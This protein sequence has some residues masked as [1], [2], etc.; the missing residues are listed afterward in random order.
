MAAATRFYREVFAHA[1]IED[2][3]DPAA[4]TWF[5]SVDDGED[6]FHYHGMGHFAGTHV[7][8]AGAA[9]LGGRRRPAVLGAPQP[10]PRRRRQLPDDGHLEPDA[11]AGGADAAHGRAAGAEL[12]A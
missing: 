7:M 11:D 1:G 5:P 6:R 9:T 10:V 3:T 8:G 2:R 4:G 12:T